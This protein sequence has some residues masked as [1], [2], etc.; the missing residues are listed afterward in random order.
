MKQITEVRKKFVV[1]FIFII[2]VLFYSFV[3]MIKS[4]DTDE[5]WRIVLSTVGFFVFLLLAGLLLKQ[6]WK[7]ERESR[8]EELKE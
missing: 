5:T 3:I 7:E 1:A 2:G 8:E 6:W 4:F